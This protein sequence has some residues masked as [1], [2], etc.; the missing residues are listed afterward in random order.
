MTVAAPP[1]ISTGSLSHRE[2]FLDALSVK[3]KETHHA[4]FR[5]GGGDGES[6]AHAG[7]HVGA[8][9]NIHNSTDVHSPDKRTYTMET[10]A[11]YRVYTTDDCQST[12]LNSLFLVL[13]FVS[14]AG[15]L[16]TAIDLYAFPPLPGASADF[17]T[18]VERGRGMYRPIAAK[19]DP[20]P[21]LRVGRNASTQSN[22][23]T[24]HESLRSR[25]LHL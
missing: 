24:A 15:Y 23:S 8:R 14:H 17:S 10:S 12:S 22:V 6:D 9:G 1:P 4:M 2:A 21:S 7:K 3:S 13:G 19:Y 11:V 5:A 18:R 25:Y 16:A 20:S